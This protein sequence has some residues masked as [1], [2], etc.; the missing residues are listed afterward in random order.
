MQSG[1]A[2]QQDAEITS[3]KARALVQL[4]AETLDCNPRNTSEEI[5]D[6]LLMKKAFDIVETSKILGVGG[7]TVINSEIVGQVL[8][9][10]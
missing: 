6:C 1:S 7:E 4:V 5:R 3:A 8:V 10:E 9:R 2:F